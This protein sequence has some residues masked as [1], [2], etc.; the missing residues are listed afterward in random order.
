MSQNIARFIVE[1]DSDEEKWQA[2]CPDCG[3]RWESQDGET[4]T[5]FLDSLVLH[6]GTCGV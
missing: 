4:D 5:D 6:I 2:T 1:L 3:E